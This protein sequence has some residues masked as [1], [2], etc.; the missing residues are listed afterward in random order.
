MLKLSD[1][2]GSKGQIIK[3]ELENQ[4]KQW[5]SSVFTSG[6]TRRAWAVQTLGTW[7]TTCNI[8]KEKSKVL[9]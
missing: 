2:W 8:I 5:I 6:F 7:F 3:V 4:T 1:A 9:A